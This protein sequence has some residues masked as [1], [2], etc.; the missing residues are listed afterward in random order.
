M[1]LWATSA[2]LRKTRIFGLAYTFKLTCSI[3]TP[4]S[5]SQRIPTLFSNSL[6]LQRCPEK[7]RKTRKHLLLNAEHLDLASLYEVVQVHTPEGKFHLS[8][9]P[10]VY[11]ILLDFRTSIDH[12]FCLTVNQLGPQHL[13]EE[14]LLDSC[15]PNIETFPQ[16][17]VCIPKNEVNKDKMAFTR[18]QL[19]EILALRG[20]RISKAIHPKKRFEQA[21]SPIIV[22][23]CNQQK[24]EHASHKDPKQLLGNGLVFQYFVHWLW[25]AFR[26]KNCSPGC[27]DAFLSTCIFYR[28]DV[29]KESQRYCRWVVHRNGMESSTLQLP[30]LQFG[31]SWRPLTNTCFAF[32]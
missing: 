26:A 13:I 19:L 16:L 23:A 24:I 10:C 29:L 1:G 12:H 3:P 5:T 4:A 14:I 11:G 20:S 2:K 25:T 27:L 15:T 6:P 28:K 22:P 32:Q 8:P 31:K 7:T 18:A 9:Y 30:R 21:D 17:G